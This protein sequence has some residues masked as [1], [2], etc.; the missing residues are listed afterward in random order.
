MSIFAVG[1]IHGR[2]DCL[3]GLLAKLPLTDDDT[4]LFLGDYVDRGPDSRGVI[5]RLIQL[6]EERGERCVCLIGNHEDMMLD[7][8]RRT[9]GHWDLPLELRINLLPAISYSPTSWEA[10]GGDATLASYPNGIEQHH[11]EFLA[12]CPLEHVVDEYH[13]V[14]AGLAERPTSSRGEVLWGISGFWPPR[15]RDTGMPITTMP[16]PPTIHKRTIVVGHTVFPE[17][18]VIPGKIGIDTGCAYGGKL[19]AVQLPEMLFHQYP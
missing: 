16:P 1:D 5:E 11:I 8:Y 17:P 14:H 6:S 9:R 15:H 7:Y 18:V 10:C 4:I 2:L 12:Q 3:N 19:T 13:F